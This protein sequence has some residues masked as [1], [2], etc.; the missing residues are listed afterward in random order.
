MNSLQLIT[1][2]HLSKGYSNGCKGSLIWDVYDHLDM[3]KEP[4]RLEQSEQ[5]RVEKGK[6]E[7]EMNI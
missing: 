6:V 4:G 2:W 7:R 3:I 1:K 5:N